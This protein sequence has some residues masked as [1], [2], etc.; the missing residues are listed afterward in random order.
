MMAP[1]PPRIDRII[2]D[3]GRIAKHV[4]HDPRTFAAFNRM[5]DTLYATGR[6]DILRMIRDNTHSPMKVYDAHRRG[7][8]DELETAETADKLVPAMLAWVDGLTD[9][10]ASP[11]HRRGL[12]IAATRIDKALPGATIH[13]AAEALQAVRGAYAK[14][15]RAFNLTRSALQAFLRDTLTK[16]HAV[17]H[18][19]AAVPG[20]RV[21]KAQRFHPLTPAEMVEQ[22]PAPESDPVDAIA[23]DMALTGMG[24]GELWGEWRVKPDRVRIE[25]TKRE[26]RKRDVPLVTAPRKPAISRKAFE[27]RLKRRTTTEARPYDFRRTYANWLESAGVPRTRRISYMGHRSGDITA[28]YERHQVADYLKAD[29][30]LIRGIIGGRPTFGPILRIVGGGGSDA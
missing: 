30:A 7:R 4:S 21:V 26:G 29:A 6:L 16:A 5:L 13:Q 28:L 20:R 12:R 10:D 1:K 19:V 9:A 18:Q 15:P 3:V 8:L 24:P 2:P 11:E 23:W 14:H 27:Q 25:G 17:Y 22:F